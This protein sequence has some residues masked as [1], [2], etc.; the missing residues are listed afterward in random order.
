[1]SHPIPLH[2]ASGLE[3][4]IHEMRQCLRPSGDESWLTRILIMLICRELN[5]FLDMLEDL[6][7]ELRAGT[8]TIARRLDDAPTLAPQRGPADHATTAAPRVPDDPVASHPRSPASRRIR[9]PGIGDRQTD[10]PKQSTAP[11]PSC[12]EITRISPRRAINRAGA[13]SR[14]DALHPS[15]VPRWTAAALGGLVEVPT[16]DY[17]VAI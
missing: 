13:G 1:M 16:L 12:T 9:T 15:T 4:S 2:P 6:L 10:A 5:R 17:V 7:A 14:G 11:S 3:R 8:L